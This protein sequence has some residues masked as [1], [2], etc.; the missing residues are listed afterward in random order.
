MPSEVRLGAQ[1]SC[2]PPSRWRQFRRAGRMPALPGARNI[3]RRR[4]YLHWRAQTRR[5]I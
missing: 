4:S 3:F 5:R 1:A 2:L